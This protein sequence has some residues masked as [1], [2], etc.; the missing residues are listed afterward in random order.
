MGHSIQYG[1]CYV[2]NREPFIN[3]EYCAPEY[4]VGELGYLITG[5][6]FNLDLDYIIISAQTE[7]DYAIKLNELITESWNLKK[8]NTPPSHHMYTH[9][10]DIGPL[11]FATINP[12]LRYLLT[13][14]RFHTA[15]LQYPREKDSIPGFV[16]PSEEWRELK[17]NYIK[18][19]C[20]NFNKLTEIYNT[21]KIYIYKKE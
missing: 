12:I 3:T 5:W 1:S 21:E 7:K 13:S 20:D 16:I 17:C 4:T 2:P 18:E 6:Q 8:Y 9:Y 14:C 10:A 15:T 11:I 19:V